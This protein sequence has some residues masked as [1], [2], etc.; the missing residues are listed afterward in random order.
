MV[1][2]TQA[3]DEHQLQRSTE[4]SI[5]TIV[6]VVAMVALMLIKSIAKKGTAQ[7]SAE[8]DIYAWV[9]S[10]LEGEAGGVAADLS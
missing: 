1:A 8:K 4:Q 6:V 10:I 9:V 2:V 3:L 5:N 7:R